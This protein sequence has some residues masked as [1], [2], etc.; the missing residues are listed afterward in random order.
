MNTFLYVFDYERVA[1][2]RYFCE[3]TQS[4]EH[5]LLKP[6]N[7]KRIMEMVRFYDLNNLNFANVKFNLFNSLKT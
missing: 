3:L 7:M 2:R 6:M 1:F 4:E 5:L